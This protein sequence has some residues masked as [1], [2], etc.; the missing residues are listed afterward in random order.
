MSIRVVSLDFDGCFFHEAYIK[1]L[2]SM[3]RSNQLPL[4]APKKENPAFTQ[5][6]VNTAVEFNHPFLSSIKSDNSNYTQ[7]ILF[8]GS[9][10]QS[11]SIDFVNRPKKGSC[12]PVIK[13][14]ATVLNFDLDS[15][16]MAD[17][18][19]DLPFGTSYERA[20]NPEETNHADWVFDETKATILYAQMHKISMEYPNEEII[21]EFYDD[22][23]DILTALKD[24][25]NEYPE[26]F[27]ENVTLRLNL[28][29][30][31]I[32]LFN[33]YKGQINDPGA[34]SI[35][36]QT[37]DE[38][39]GEGIIDANFR[40]TVKE[41][42]TISMAAK[43]RKVEGY[44][45]INASAHVSPGLLTT[46]MQFKPSKNHVPVPH[47]VIEDV[48]SDSLL[49]SSSPHT[50]FNQPNPPHPSPRRFGNSDP[51]TS[52]RKSV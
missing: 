44:V 6:R 40:E 9:N 34:V 50:M 8:I 11:E 30:G 42:A 4:N 23:L 31:P 48:L 37:I 29:K 16:L 35:T 32:T 20:M 10:R 3:A 7:S 47:P 27:P 19:G 41:M 39:D 38:I 24:F 52:L 33:R 5:L 25:Y 22:R 36:I 26:L 13:K 43:T 12:F 46:R 18:Y 51:A 2:E 45:I 1:A 28:Y 49:L 14:I 21:F 15:S 17:I